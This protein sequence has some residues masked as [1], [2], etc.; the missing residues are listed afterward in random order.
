MVGAEHRRLEV[1]PQPVR[2]QQPVDGRHGGPL[3]SCLARPP[4][5]IEQ[6]AEQRDELRE[7]HGCDGAACG[8]DGRRETA[9]GSLDARALLEREDVSGEDRQ[10]GVDV[11]LRLTSPAVAEIELRQ[12]DVRPGGRLGDT[13]GGVQREPHRRPGSCAVTAELA[14][15]RDSR[16]RRHARLERG[17]PVER[18]ERGAIAAELDQRVADHAVRP[19]GIGRAALRLAAKREGAPEVVADQREVAE[20]ERRRRILR[21]Q[22]EHP[23]ERP[24]GERQECRVA[25]FAPAHLVGEPEVV[26]PVRIGA[27]ARELPLQLRDGRRCAAVTTE[28]RQHGPGID[29]GPSRCRARRPELG[30][31]ACEQAAEA[32]RGHGR[33]SHE[34]SRPP[35]HALLPLGWF[36]SARHP[37]RSGRGAVSAPTGNRGVRASGVPLVLSKPDLGSAA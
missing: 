27:G 37:V 7:R 25:R 33:A 31:D 18:R 1:D 20:R 21:A 19:R 10:R 9:L 36:A 17:H 12:L 3:A 8:R 11:R 13:A 29:R 4:L 2:C 5:P 6:V 26:E 34:K 23:A 35:P 22:R 14:G 32:E 15:V 30:H 16:I 24:L 28:A